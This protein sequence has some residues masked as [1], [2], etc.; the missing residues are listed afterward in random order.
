M[1]SNFIHGLGNTSD[2]IHSM[3]RYLIRN[4]KSLSFTPTFIKILVF[5]RLKVSQTLLFSRFDIQPSS[6]VFQAKLSM[7]RSNTLC[8]FDVDGTLTLPQRVIEK[9][10]ES[11]VLNDIKPL[12]SIGIVGGSDLKKIAF[13]MGGLEVVNNFDYVFAE[14][15]LVA[16]KYGTELPSQTIQAHV[17]EEKLQRFINY[18]LLYM[19]KLHLPVKRG[20]FIEF[21]RGLINVSPVGRSCSMEERRQFNEYDKQHNIRK[22]FVESLRKEFPDLGLV[23]SIGGEISF[24]VFP[25]GWDKTYCLRHVKDQNFEHIHFF[26]DKTDPGGNDFEIF[27]HD[28]TIGHRV[29]SYKDTM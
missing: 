11:F 6:K 13:Q 16:Y 19:S 20:T 5:K 23:Y 1:Y 4:H 9:E 2:S 21:R 27:S 28:Q 22:D 29:Q 10:M 12:T 18:C 25:K 15:G 24:D 3:I 7:N 8:L 17:G 14:N 26:G